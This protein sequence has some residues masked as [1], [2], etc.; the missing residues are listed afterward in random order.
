[1]PHESPVIN[2]QAPLLASAVFK[3]QIAGHVFSF[4]LFYVMVFVAS[5]Q[6]FHCESIDCLSLVGALAPPLPPTSF[7]FWFIHVFESLNIGSSVH[8]ALH[9]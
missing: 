2:L 1:M 4:Y 7:L 8:L 5:Y 3:D 6:L 9:R